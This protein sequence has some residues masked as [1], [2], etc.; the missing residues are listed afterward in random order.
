LAEFVPMT[1]PA[2]CW[3]LFIGLVGY[4]EIFIHQ[5]REEN[6]C[7]RRW[8]PCWIIQFALAAPGHPFKS[9]RRNLNLID[10]FG[11]SNQVM[12]AWH[13]VT[14]PIFPHRDPNC[15]DLN[16]R[17]PSS[18]VPYLRARPAD[19]LCSPLPWAGD[20]QPVGPLT[21]RLSRQLKHW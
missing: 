8:Y 16:F 6:Y 2:M 9:L 4:L 10:Y 20:R 15:H 12:S 18:P 3:Q 11:A 1:I 7:M 17:P 13:I 14:F 5:S 19:S 21:Y